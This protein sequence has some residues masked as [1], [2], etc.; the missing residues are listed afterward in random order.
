MKPL[1]ISPTAPRRR[2]PDL[3]PVMDVVFI[4]VVFFMVVSTFSQTL[5]KPLKVS[6][7]GIAV[8]PLSP[9]ELRVLELTAT[10]AV[11]DG[12]AVTDMAASL[13]A[14]TSKPLS[15]VA[16]EGASY[17]AL[18]DALDAAQTAGITD[19][20]VRAAGDGS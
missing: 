5:V 14:D 15:I 4:L 2:T 9:V 8:P 11:I 6:V 17:Q 12:E 1:R 18:V 20:R 16:G 19:V 10:G 7:P 13:A 3:T